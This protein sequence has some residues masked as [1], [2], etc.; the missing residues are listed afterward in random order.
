MKSTNHVKCAVAPTKTD[1]LMDEESPEQRQF[2]GYI[3]EYT[4][5]RSAECFTVA[6]VLEYL[7]FCLFQITFLLL[8]A[9]YTISYIVVSKYKQRNDCEDYYSGKR[10]FLHGAYCRPYVFT[11]EED[12][13]VC[14]I[15]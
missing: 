15:M 1:V 5:S 12:A 3:R 7:L 13:L 11:G 14:R 9:L 6:S 8:T 2:Y 4:V 10:S